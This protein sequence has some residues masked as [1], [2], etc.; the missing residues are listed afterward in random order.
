MSVAHVSKTVTPGQL[1]LD[2]HHGIK[3]RIVVPISVSKERVKFG[4]DDVMTFKGLGLDISFW[5][6]GEM[7]CTFATRSWYIESMT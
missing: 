7:S 6:N 3:T 4:G 2:H 5:G 1:I